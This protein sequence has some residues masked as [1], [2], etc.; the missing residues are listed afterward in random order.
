MTGLFIVANNTGQ[1]HLNHSIYNLAE[2][3]PPISGT[4][5]HEIRL[6]LGNRWGTATTAV[7]ASFVMVTA[8]QGRRTFGD[9]ADATPVGAT[10]A[11]HLPTAPSYSN[12]VC[13][14]EFGGIARVFGTTPRPFPVPKIREY[15][16][17]NPACWNDDENNL[18]SQRGRHGASVP[19]NCWT[20]WG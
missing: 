11:L 2:Q 8:W 3:A 16:L 7:R 13:L 18:L 19:C 14:N 4:D 12:V 17:A 15:I 20:S 9:V 6:L 10:H 1:F 5:R